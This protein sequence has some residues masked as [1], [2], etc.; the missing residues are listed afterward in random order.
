MTYDRPC[1]ETRARILETARKLFN[2]HGLHR[3]GVRDIARATEMSPGNLAYHFSTKDALVSALM[4]QL[5]E[6]NSKMVFAELPADF[7]LQ[8]LYGAARVA[9]ENMLH[10]R[11]LLLS[12]ADAVAASPELQKLEASFSPKRRRRHDQMIELLIANEYLGGA[13]RSDWLYE[14]GSIISGGWL[15]HGTLRRMSDAKMVLHYAKVGCSVLR[16][17][18]TTRGARQMNKILAGELD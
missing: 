14:Q 5:H 11:F 1:V 15:I 18:C 4:M 16:P 8:H 17:F 2:E 7:S 10:F 12:Y 9:M 3:I 13:A 6:L